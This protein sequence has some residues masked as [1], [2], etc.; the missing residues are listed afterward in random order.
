M[1]G[2]GH[3]TLREERGQTLVE[4]A[5]VLPLLAL[6]LFA[7]IQFGIVYNNYISL[8]DAVRAGARRGA[9]SRFVADP[10]ATTQQAV[11]DAA[12]PDLQASS[13]CTDGNVC[14]T[15]SSD[16][17]PGD[18]VTVQATYPYSINLFGIVVASGNLSSKTV[19]R[20]E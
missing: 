6:V 15:V 1:R 12:S 8:T 5:L 19:E 20:V 16:W 11:I 17:Q 2:R 14:V 10:T 18:T 9:V 7:V 3:T 13:P 4:F